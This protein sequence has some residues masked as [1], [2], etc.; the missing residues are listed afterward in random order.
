VIPHF[1]VVDFLSFYIELLV[2]ALMY[3]VWLVVHRVLKPTPGFAAQQLTSSSTVGGIAG[4][5]SQATMRPPTRPFF[6]FV[7][8]SRVDLYHDE[9]ED[10]PFDKHE[11]D[12][13]GRRLGGLAGWAWALYYYI[14]A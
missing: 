5:S 10:E 8:L 6:D 3:F 9:H 7:D 4:A 12:V 13:R 11:D 14:I 1:S 2:M